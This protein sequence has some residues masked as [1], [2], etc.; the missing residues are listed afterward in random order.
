MQLIFVPTVP[1]SS[2]FKAKLRADTF[3]IP[4]SLIERVDKYNDK[5]SS[6]S[7]SIDIATKDGRVIKIN[8]HI[9]QYSGYLKFSDLIDK[10][11]YATSISEFFALKLFEHDPT[12]ENE[13][14]GW[15]LYNLDKDF[16]R[17]GIYFSKPADGEV[18][19]EEEPI[20]QKI[21]NRTPNGVICETYPPEF[22]VPA[23]MKV[24]ELIECS[25][26]RSKQRR[27]V[28]VYNYVNDEGET[29]TLWRSSQ[30]LVSK[31]FHASFL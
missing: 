30:C 15:T 26:F 20:Y 4:F 10:V 17:Q 16:E 18:E 21:Q 5:K 27:P 28:M 22:V 12:L 8:F 3:V 11:P 29:A 25:K 1:L 19:V 7:N 2:A 31:F 23:L 24:E 13:F 9:E 14:K 6:F